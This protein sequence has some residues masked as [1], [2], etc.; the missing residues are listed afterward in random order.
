MERWRPRPELNRR[1][2]FC[3]PLRNHSATWPGESA[4]LFNSGREGPHDIQERCGSGNAAKVYEVFQGETCVLCL[5]AA[6]DR[7]SSQDSNRGSAVV[8]Y[9]QARQAM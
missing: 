5:P 2:R 1:K 6:K 7:A 3:R 4:E 9:A 8:D